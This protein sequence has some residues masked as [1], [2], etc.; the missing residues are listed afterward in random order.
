[1]GKTSLPVFTHPLRYFIFYSTL[2][3]ECICTFSCHT[4]FSGKIGCTLFKTWKLLPVCKSMLI[5][6]F[7]FWDLKSR[8]RGCFHDTGAT[9][10]PAWAHSSSLSYLCICLHDA[11]KKCR[12]GETHTGMSLLQ[13]GNRI[14]LALV[15]VTSAWHFLVESRKQIQS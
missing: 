6:G 14:D 1:M 11:T 10:A 15:W 4:L 8:L 12:A 13:C 5:W 3:H 2:A 7:K 9:F